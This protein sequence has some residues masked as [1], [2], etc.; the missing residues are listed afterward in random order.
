ML[1]VKVLIIVAVVSCSSNSNDISSRSARVLV[2]A[3]GR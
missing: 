1:A 2:L 3:I